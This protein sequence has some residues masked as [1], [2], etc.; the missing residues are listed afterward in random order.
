MKF[1]LTDFVIWLSIKGNFLGK[2]LNDWVTS[3]AGHNDTAAWIGV[4]FPSYPR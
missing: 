3:Q 4:S 1:F 2:S